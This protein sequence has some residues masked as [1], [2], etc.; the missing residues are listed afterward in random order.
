MRAREARR[1]EVPA[2]KTHCAEC[3]A[4]F[5]ST[6]EMREV[7]SGT[8]VYVHSHECEGFSLSPG[9]TA[10]LAVLGAVVVFLGGLWLFA[11]VSWFYWVGLVA[12]IVGCVLAARVIVWAGHGR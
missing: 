6:G 4:E 9:I 3:G 7:G 5:R 8:G 12:A 1:C 11:Q 2:L 10:P